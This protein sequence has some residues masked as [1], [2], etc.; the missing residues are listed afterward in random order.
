MHTQ[1]WRFW[2][3]SMD[4]WWSMTEKRKH[5]IISLIWWC[6]VVLGHRTVGKAPRDVSG[7]KHPGS[8]ALLANSQ[9]AP[10][11]KPFL[12]T[13]L[14]FWTHFQLSQIQLQHR[15]TAELIG[16][17][18]KDNTQ[19]NQRPPEL[20][21]WFGQPS[22]VAFIST[23]LNRAAVFCKAEHFEKQGPSVYTSGHQRC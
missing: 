5:N 9:T 8:T 22:P 14:I 10:S 15:V 18:S 20:D 3:H 2:W 12:P 16:L 4:F 21:L 7:S 19:E 11:F 13:Q 6:G 23:A 17:E 1:N